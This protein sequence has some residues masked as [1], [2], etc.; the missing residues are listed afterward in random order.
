MNKTFCKIF[1]R[2]LPK[3]SMKFVNVIMLT[4]ILLSSITGAVQA[5]AE[6]KDVSKLIPQERA[7]VTADDTYIPPSFTHPKARLATQGSSSEKYLEPSVLNSTLPDPITCTSDLVNMGCEQ[8]DPYTVTITKSGANNNT[9]VSGSVIAPNDVPIY[10]RIIGDM[11]YDNNVNYSSGRWSP[12]FHNLM[13]IHLDSIYYQ[14]SSYVTSTFNSTY[15]FTRTVGT[16]DVATT[17]IKTSSGNLKFD[18]V[19]SCIVGC[20]YS[21][22]SFSGNLLFQLS[23]IPYTHK[24]LNVSTTYH[25]DSIRTTL[26]QNADGNTISI[27]N[28]SGFTV[29]DEVL[30]MAMIGT[31]AGLYETAYL[32]AVLP[33]HLELTA[34]L[35]YTYD[36]AAGPVMVQQVPYFGAVTVASGGNITAHAWNGTT[37]GVVF[38]RADSVTVQTGGKID[39]S[40]L[41][42]RGSGATASGEG[43]G[44]GIGGVSY[45]WDATGGGGGSYGGSGYQGHKGSS[46]SGCWNIWGSLPGNGY[47]EAILDNLYLGS[48]GGGGGRSLANSGKPGRAGRAG[49]GVIYFDAQIVNVNGG[50]LSNGLAATSKTT[51][52]NMDDGGGGGGSGGSVY[53][54]AQNITI[55]PSASV[56]A[57]GGVGNTNRNSTCWGNGSVTLGGQGG[58]GRIRLDYSNLSGNTTPPPGYS[59]VISGNN[60][61]IFAGPTTVEADGVTAST[62][63]VTVYDTANTPIQGANVTLHTTGSASIIQPVTPTNSLGKATGQITNTVEETV[64]VSAT[65]NGVLLDDTV[66]LTFNYKVDPSLSTLTVN[67]ESVIANGASIAIITAALKNAV[68]IPV[69]NR[70]VEIALISGTGLSINDQN[71]GID[72]Y[73]TIGNTDSNGIATAVLKTTLAGVRTFKARSGQELITQLGTANF[74]AGPVS[75]TTSYVT[76]SPASAPADGQTPINVTVVARDANNNPIEG[77]TVI[78]S[79]SG[80][81]AVVTQPAATNAQGFAI[82]T[83]VNNT[84]ESIEVSVEINGEAI[85]DKASAVF[86]GADLR[87]LLTA[88][89]VLPIGANVQYQVDVKNIDNLAAQNVSLVVD[90]PA[91]VTYSHSNDAV[92]PSQSGQTLTWALGDFA[93]GAG[94]VFTIFGSLG[95][96]IPAGTVLAA[97]GVLTSTTSE[98]SLGNNSAT[99]STQVVDG[100]SFVSSISPLSKTINANSAATYGIQINNTGL[101]ADTFNLAVNGLDPSWYALPGTEFN[102]APGEIRTVDLNLDFSLQSNKCALPTNIPFSVN[103]SSSNR[104]ETKAAEVNL[105]LGPVVT[106]V[107][108]VN[109]TSFGS[110]DVIFSWKT[111][112]Q[113]TG[114]LHVY[115]V[116]QP[117]QDIVYSTPAS[118]SHSAAVKNLTRN[119]TYE[120]YVEAATECG[121]TLSQTRQFTIGSGVV[122]KSHELSY[123]INRDYDQTA[124]VWVTNQ[125][126]VA[127]NVNLKI[128]ESYDDLIVNFRGS[129]SI[130]GDVTLLPGETRSIELAFFAQDAEI[131][132]YVINAVLTSTDTNGTDTESDLAVIRVKVLF[133]GD[134]TIEEISVD[135]ILNIA[136]Y[137]LTNKGMPITDLNITVEDPTTHLPA[138]AM[139]TPQIYHA[140]VDKGKTLDFRVIPLYS[141]DQAVGPVSSSIGQGV[142]AMPAKNA[143]TDILYDIVSKVAEDVQ[144]TTV[145]KNCDGNI[146]A[147]TFNGPISV[148]LPYN[149]WYCPNRTHVEIGL[150]TPP[151]VDADN[152]LGGMLQMGFSPASVAAPHTVAISMNG[153][154]LG[155]MQGIPKGI[156]SFNLSPTNI[157]TGFMTSARQTVTID[158]HFANFAHYQIGTGGNLIVVMDTVT[159]F[160]CAHSQEEARQIAI[161][162]YGLA[163]VAGTLNVQIERPNA[164]FPAD[165]DANGFV[166]VRA[167]VG[168]NLPAFSN[169]YSVSAE[170]KYLDMPGVPTDSFPLFNDG[171]TGHGDDRANDRY[172]NAL[173]HPRFGGNMRL[174][175]TASTGYGLS[176]TATRDFTVNA[177]PDFEVKSVSIEK[178]SR[179]GEFVK[180]WTEIA[181]NGFTVAGPVAVEFRYYTAT[182]EGVK[183]GAPLYISRQELFNTILNN[184]F[185]RGEVIKVTDNNFV[186]PEVHLYY[187]EVVVDP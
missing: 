114:K 21:A 79:A 78:L 165:L 185:E 98:E 75:P 116:G 170:V 140:R 83:V 4:S 35:K 71:V 64:S 172:F 101:L 51:E 89:T 22:M 81:N 147:V 86:R 150:S 136:T 87:L 38:F 187:V 117:G 180:V 42:Y 52:C 73:L 112:A 134:Y 6:S 106:D 28:S 119:A 91:G 40:G 167:F 102:L 60:S 183:I 174:T 1:L 139:V 133:P 39:V 54:K 48:G 65:V 186:A 59:Q 181:N 18:T 31:Q 82:G 124:M 20:S 10:V 104:A 123:E 156:Y 171:Q 105:Q 131:K 184:S 144:R 11:G 63:T 164:G 99:V 159:V 110:R 14:P 115:P 45:Y 113:A 157:N 66:D 61:N 8:V 95:T 90:L 145:R 29:G 125:D 169:L 155:S 92:L 138:L 97:H 88:P 143:V 17:I 163:P 109:N 141:A 118:T 33:D 5:R 9:N 19:A 160:V 43:P 100:R 182:D 162:T 77:A 94:R 111:D 50:I 72:Q 53:I 126:T 32:S 67:P 12:P 68:G 41:G 178:I 26:T 27:A 168:D 34:N 23:T 96:T 121:A 153:D 13:G 161:D 177:Q 146:Y 58:L 127:R 25:T 55:D 85:Q 24:P 74:M 57:T 151:F 93:A 176:D 84:N 69:P 107:Y 149:T 142:M 2:A 158:A 37:G 137:R 62:I 76:A 179:K 56:S 15:I 49:G 46:C 80:G 166:N 70:L 47:G 3:I 135:P 130:D 129:G 175:V 120:W 36:I 30:V 152:L 132:N 44:G 103:I 7:A 122:F 148:S 128:E 154:P 16:F 173:W 108:P